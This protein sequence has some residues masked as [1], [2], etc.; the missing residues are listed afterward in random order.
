M[1]RFASTRMVGVQKVSWKG[2][3]R[4]RN[5]AYFLCDFS[6]LLYE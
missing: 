4:E 1:R 3:V 2:K 5:K 6:L